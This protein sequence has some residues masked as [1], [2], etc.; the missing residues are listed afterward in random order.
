MEIDKDLTQKPAMMILNQVLHL[1]MRRSLHILEE[2]GLKPGQVGTLMTLSKNGGLSQREVAK[3]IG[4]TP[5]SITVSLQKMEKQGYIMRRP[6][7]KDQRI[8]RIEITDKGRSC[9][10]LIEKV[11]EQ[12]DA[13][14]FEGMSAEEKMLFRRLL[15]QMNENLLKGQDGKEQDKKEQDKKDQ[16]LCPHII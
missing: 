8:I 4:V 15:L 13:M 5:P 3:A 16:G 12:V 6:D 2:Y 9:V 7:E 10:A 1:T 14:L 11:V